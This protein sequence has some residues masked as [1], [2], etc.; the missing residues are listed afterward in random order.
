MDTIVSKVV[1]RYKAAKVDFRQTVG[2]PAEA[3]GSLSSAYQAL[4][5][6]KL[7]LDD[8]EEIPADLMPLYRQVMKTLDK[9]ATA[10]QET[11]QLREMVRKIRL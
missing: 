5:L 10:K 6:F 7:G 9:V 3:D 11:H 8:M 2:K 4:H 1:D